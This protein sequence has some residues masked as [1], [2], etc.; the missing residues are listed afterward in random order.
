MRAVSPSA[1]VV[2]GYVLSALGQN[3]GR[4]DTADGAQHAGIVVEKTL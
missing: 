1:R 2:S 4:M 3:C